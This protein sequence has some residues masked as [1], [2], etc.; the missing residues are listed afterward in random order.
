VKI[1]ADQAKAIRVDD[2][3][4]AARALIGRAGGASIFGEV[5]PLI[6][7]YN[8]A[9]PLPTELLGDALLSVQADWYVAISNR[10]VALLAA[11]LETANAAILERYKEAAAEAAASPTKGK[12]KATAAAGRR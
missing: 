10:Q 1:E 11:R 6:A 4:P 3:A 9:S 12:R 2:L 8:A 5:L 7:N